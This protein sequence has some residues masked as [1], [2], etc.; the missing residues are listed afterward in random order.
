MPAL[1]H[2]LQEIQATAAPFDGCAGF[3]VLP[4]GPSYAA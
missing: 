1:R 4:D 3:A 2:Y